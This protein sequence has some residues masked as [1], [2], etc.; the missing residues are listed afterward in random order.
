MRDISQAL[1]PEWADRLFAA[2][3]KGAT[4]KQLQQLAAD[5]LVQMYFRA[6]NTRAASLSVDIDANTID[7]MQIDL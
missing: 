6:N 5:G 2:H 1:P 3:E 4:E 7:H